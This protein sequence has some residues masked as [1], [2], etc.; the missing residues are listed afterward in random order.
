MPPGGSGT[1]VKVGR[2]V[3]VLVS[4]SGFT[5]GLVEAARRQE[6]IILVDPETMA[7]RSTADG[8]G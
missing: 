8:E 2:P 3:V 5:P 1:W 4:R 7:Q 6:R